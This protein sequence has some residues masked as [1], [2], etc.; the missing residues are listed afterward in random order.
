[1]IRNNHP[2]FIFAY[3]NT[4]ATLTDEHQGF[5]RVG[6]EGVGPYVFVSE[7]TPA[8]GYSWQ[9][10]GH[11]EYKQYRVIGWTM[12]ESYGGTF[13]LKVY[14][15]DVALPA[16]LEGSTLFATFAEAAS[17]A[18]NWIAAGGPG[19]SLEH[20]DETRRKRAVAASEY[21]RGKAEHWLGQLTDED[22]TKL[23]EKC[24]SYI[25]QRAERA[26]KAAAREAAKVEKARLKAAEKEAKEAAKAAKA[27][28]KAAKAAEKEA[29]KVAKAAKAQT[30]SS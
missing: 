1:M 2:N 15:G 5:G 10:Y 16:S 7:P 26:A 13:G 4:L 30:P 22:L 9:R 6:V 27:T 28:E 11:N 23:S 25:A 12:P 8:G 21:A 24:L 19:I 17:V 20:P 18:S 14:P 3:N 29:A